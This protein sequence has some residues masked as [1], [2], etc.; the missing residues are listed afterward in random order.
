MSLVSLDTNI[1]IWAIKK[2]ASPGQ[3]EMIPK[4]NNLLERISR[5]N[6]R[7]MVSTIVVSELLMNVNPDSIPVMTSV[8]EKTFIVVPFDIQSA[9]MFARIWQEKNGAIEELKQS[10]I[11]RQQLKAD[12]LIVASAI[13]RKA[14]CIY[15]NDKGLQKFAEGFIDVFGI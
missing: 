6:Q 14:I 4:A 10:G 12:C 5:S 8:I 1:L 3:E 2:Q 9:M 13:A 11:G 15:S 7:A